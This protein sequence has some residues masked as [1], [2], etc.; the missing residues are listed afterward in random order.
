MVG[1][2]ASSNNSFLLLF[3]KVVINLT[4]LLFIIV[5][6]LLSNATFGFIFGCLLIFYF[7]SLGGTPSLGDR[8]F[9]GW[10]ATKELM[11]MKPKPMGFSPKIVG[12][13]P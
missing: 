7:C 8:G 10:S 3:F 2:I 12:A 1:G 13:N 6:L 4:L 5:V 11:G 9:G